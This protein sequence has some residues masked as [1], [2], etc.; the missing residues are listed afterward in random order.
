MHITANKELPII[1]KNSDSRQIKALSNESGLLLLEQA[2]TDQL[3]ALFDEESSEDSGGGY[4][5]ELIPFLVQEAF[6]TSPELG[7][8]HEIYKELSEKLNLKVI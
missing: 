1:P 8:G 7:V 4:Y 5:R 3:Q 2:F 6:K